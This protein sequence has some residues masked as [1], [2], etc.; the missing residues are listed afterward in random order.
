MT[1]PTV[2]LPRFIRE[3][4]TMVR[5]RYPLIY[6]VSHEEQLG[7]RFDRV[8]RLDEIAVAERRAAA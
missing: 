8:L 3:L 4:E 7:S 5:A 1:E 2:P 6:L